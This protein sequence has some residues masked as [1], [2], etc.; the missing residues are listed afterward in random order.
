VIN[1]IE[2]LFGM[3]AGGF[4]IAL[5]MLWRNRKEWALR[6]AL[7]G[8]IALALAIGLELYVRFAA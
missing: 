7:I 4:G 6:G 8:G 3:A 2:T 1:L 5:F